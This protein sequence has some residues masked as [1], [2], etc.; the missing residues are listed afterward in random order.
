MLENLNR[1]KLNLK[2]AGLYLMAI[3][4]IIFFTLVLVAGK[5]K[6]SLHV[7]Y[8]EIDGARILPHHLLLSAV[9]VPTQS[10]LDT[11]DLYIIKR[12]LLKHPY[13]QSVNINRSYPDKLRIEVTEREPI[14]SILNDHL[15][16]VD[17]AGILLPAIES[18]IPMDLP[19]ITGISDL[20]PEEIGT[21][22]KNKEI[23]TA[24]KILQTSIMVDTSLFHFISEVNMNSGQDIIIT[25]TEPAV[26]IILGRD[27]YAAKLLIFQSFW[28]NFVKTNDVNKVQHI[29]LRYTDQVVVNW[30]N[31]KN[32]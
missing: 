17:T 5:W 27:D 24:V 7:E 15:L 32:N 25:T 19:I 23:E 18:E 8:I 14:A 22:L 26:P 6:T 21:K 20:K 2:R 4:I 16:Y 31:D 3:L 30:I 12:R 11:V 9:N 28:T 1:K 10:L 29:D 13:I